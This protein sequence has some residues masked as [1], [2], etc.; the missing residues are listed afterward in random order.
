M[1]H[2]TSYSPC[3]NTCTPRCVADL[4]CHQRC[5][6]PSHP[7]SHSCTLWAGRVFVSPPVKRFDR[8]SNGGRPCGRPVDSRAGTHAPLFYK[9]LGV[10]RIRTRRH[11]L[12]FLLAANSSV[13]VLLSSAVARIPAVAMDNYC[14]LPASLPLAPEATLL[15][16]DTR[17]KPLANHPHAHKLTT[18]LLPIGSLFVTYISTVS[19]SS[20]LP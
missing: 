15:A 14:L 1:L 10:Q 7:P 20:L 6:Q 12:E 2:P 4:S 3:Q 19:F 18:L 5:Q 16:D 13:S 9:S 8:R 17:T 11:S